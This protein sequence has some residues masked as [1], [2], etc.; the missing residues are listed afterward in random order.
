MNYGFQFTFHAE[1]NSPAGRTQRDSMP[2]WRSSRM[3]QQVSGEMA[4]QVFCQG[5]QRA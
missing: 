2:K 1:G 4:S 3:A 5:P